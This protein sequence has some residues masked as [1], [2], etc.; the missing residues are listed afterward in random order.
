[1]TLADMFDGLTLSNLEGGDALLSGSIPDQAALQGVLKRISSLGLTL[2]SV[3]TLSDEDR[4]EGD[5]TMNTKS[6]FLEHYALPLFIILTPLISLAIPLFLHVPPEI[7]P[8]MMVLVPALIAIVLTTLTDGRKGV[9]VLLKKLFQWRIGF[10]W[11]AIVFGLAFGLRLTMSALA[12]LLGWIPAIQLTPWSLPQY[13]I[14]GVFIIIGAIAEELSWRGFILPKLLT[15]RSPLYSALF[16]GVIWGVIHLGL[17]LPGQMNAGSHWLPSIL[18]IIGLSVVLTWLYIQTRGNLVI[19]ILF[20]F[21]QSYFVF[22]NGGI[23]LTQQ[24]WL[25]TAITVVVSLVLIL[26][27]GPDLQREPAKKSAI[28]AQ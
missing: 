21:G 5:I 8:L 1:V 22:L 26:I 16:I 18:Y 17:I 11:Y 12:L 2:V 14:I 13:I 24:L 23:S 20:H 7:V 6:T 15:N 28:V 25:M 19:P 27:Y 4:M 9:G 10:K 3:N